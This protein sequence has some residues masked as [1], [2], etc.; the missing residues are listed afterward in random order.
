VRIDLDQLQ[1][2]VQSFGAMS[3]GGMVEDESDESGY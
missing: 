1:S 3:G 2:L